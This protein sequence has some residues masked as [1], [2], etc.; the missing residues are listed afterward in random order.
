MLGFQSPLSCYCTIFLIFS[1]FYSSDAK[2]S[3]IFIFFQLSGTLCPVMCLRG[4]M[5]GI[6]P[7]GG[8]PLPPSNKFTFVLQASST[9]GR[10]LSCLLSEHEFGIN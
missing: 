2:Y 5:R 10:A 1:A 6:C 3:Y 4:F 7:C 8:A 9:G